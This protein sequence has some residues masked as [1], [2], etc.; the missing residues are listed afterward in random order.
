MLYHI[1]AKAAILNGFSFERLLRIPQI[2]KVLA[3]RIIM[4]KYYRNRD[5]ISLIKGIGMKR[6]LYIYY[7]IDTEY[8]W[9]PI[10]S[11]IVSQRL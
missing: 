11:Y 4:N 3:K 1:T 9:L 5:E 6:K 7:A 2:G 10:S 8:K